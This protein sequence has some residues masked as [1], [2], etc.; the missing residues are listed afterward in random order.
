MKGEIG[1][2]GGFGRLVWQMIQ[3]DIENNP[4]ES[5]SPQMQLFLIRL[6]RI[7][8]WRSPHMPELATNWPE[9]LEMIDKRMNTQALTC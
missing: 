8:Q 9:L 5:V 2:I 3:R 7:E 4:I 1:S 6:G